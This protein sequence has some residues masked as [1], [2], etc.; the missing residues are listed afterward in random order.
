MHTKWSAK[1]IHFRETTKSFPNIYRLSVIK[2][3]GRRAKPVR[4]ED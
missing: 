4:P 2:K 1:I 3:T